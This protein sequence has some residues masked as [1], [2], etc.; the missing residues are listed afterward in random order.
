M[1]NNL[2]LPK[3]PKMKY[4]NYNCNVV[5]PSQLKRITNLLKQEV[6][7][8][9]Y[10]DYTKSVKVVDRSGLF[11]FGEVMDRVLESFGG[12]QEMME[13]SWDIDNNFGIV[14]CLMNDWRIFHYVLKAGEFSILN[15]EGRISKIN[16]ECRIFEDMDDW[17]H[18]KEY[19][20]DDINN[21]KSLIKNKVV[22][23]LAEYSEK[24]TEAV[25]S[26]FNGDVDAIAKLMTKNNGNKK[27]YGDS[28]KSVI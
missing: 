3:I 5:N 20:G 26:L 11:M 23:N 28:I 10:I 16:R 25:D 24:M 6:I 1:E 22:E 7:P 18:W 4:L 21:K 13:C 8:A 12:V 15:D 14:V 19:L 2:L 9:E 27:T 17:S